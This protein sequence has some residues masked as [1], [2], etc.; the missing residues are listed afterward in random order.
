MKANN[1]RLSQ[2]DNEISRLKKEKDEILYKIERE[3][4]NYDRFMTTYSGKKLLEEYSLT[5]S[6]VWE[7][8]GEDPNC[9]FGGYHHTPFLGL[10][11]GTL[12]NVIRTAVE[13]S[14]FWQWGGGGEIKPYKDKKYKINKV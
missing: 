3:K 8:Y 1:K 9:D 6:G 7:V 11:E 2:I 5:E 14:S 12:E 10:Y 13:L 4:T